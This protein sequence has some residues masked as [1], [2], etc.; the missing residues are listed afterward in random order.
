MSHKTQRKVRIRIDDAGGSLVDISRDVDSWRLARTAE[1]LETSTLGDSD[2]SHL[3]GLCGAALLLGGPFNDA[4]P[5]TD[6]ILFD[7]LGSSVAR[8]VE[9]GVDARYYHFEA[10]VARYTLGG[11]LDAPGLVTWEAA[12][13]VSGAVNRTSVAL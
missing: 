5:Q 3:P 4:A 7:A 1:I 10:V 2:R 6:A 9:V 13:Q 8:T 12:L 11:S